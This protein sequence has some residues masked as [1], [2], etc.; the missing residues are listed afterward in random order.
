MRSP[1][2]G[3]RLPNS[4]WRASSLAVSAHRRAS[5]RCPIGASRQQPTITEREFGQ[6]LQEQATSIAQSAAMRGLLARDVRNN[7]VTN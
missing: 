7:G 1:T 6:A 2:A 4:A 5:G 3:S